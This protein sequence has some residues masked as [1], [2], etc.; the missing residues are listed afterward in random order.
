MLIINRTIFMPSHELL[1]ATSTTEKIAGVMRAQCA[2]C[3]YS[4]DMYP[5]VDGCA[6][7]AYVKYPLAFCS[8]LLVWGLK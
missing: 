5:I 4:S 8:S 6:L 7:G 1:N 3:F 2:P